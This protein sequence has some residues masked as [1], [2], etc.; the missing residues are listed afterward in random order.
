MGKWSIDGE[1]A[2]LELQYRS[3]EGEKGTMKIRHHMVDA[4]TKKLTISSGENEEAAEVT[5]VR[6]KK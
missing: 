5:L 2:V 6:S 3:G 4:D 1:D